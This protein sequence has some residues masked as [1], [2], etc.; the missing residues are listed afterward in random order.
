MSDETW[1]NAQAAFNDVDLVD[2]LRVAAV[3][4][5]FNL[6]NVVLGIGPDRLA[7]TAHG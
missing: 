5:Y 1:A 2:L 3:E 4:N 6:T 7:K